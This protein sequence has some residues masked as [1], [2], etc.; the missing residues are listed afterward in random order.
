[1]II[2]KVNNI[3]FS[4]RNVDFTAHVV[5]SPDVKGDIMIP[6]SITYTNREYII[7]T[8]E[9]KSFMNNKLLKSITFPEDSELL[10]IRNEAFLYSSIEYLTI[11]SKVQ[12]MEEGWCSNVKHLKNVILSPNNPNFIY[13]DEDRKMIAS[14][15]DQNSNNYDNLI[16]ACRDIEY[17]IIPSFIKRI[18]DHCFQFC[19][20]IKNFEFIDIESSQLLSIGKWSFHQSSISEIEIPKQ[21]Q[22][23]QQEAF[24]CCSNL[25]KIEI[26]E[27]SKLNEID[28][29]SFS[30][31]SIENFFIPSNV[32]IIQEGCFN[33]SLNLKKVT[34]SLENKHFKY[35]DFERKI[36]V[37]KSNKNINDYDVIIFACREISNAFIPSF[38]TRINQFAFSFCVN[39]NEVKFEKNSKLNS[40]G[41]CAFAFS[42]LKKISFPSQIKIIDDKAFLQCIKLKSITFKKPKKLKNDNSN[43]LNGQNYDGLKGQNL[44]VQKI[45]NFNVQNLNSLRSSNKFRDIRNL[46]GN[47]SAEENMKLQINGDVFFLCKNLKSFEFLGDSVQIGKLCFYDCSDFIV[48]S[49]PNAQ[50]VVASFDAFRKVEKDFTI[51]IK[52]GSTFEVIND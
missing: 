42:M 45:G 6:R 31:C 37:G 52:F 25:R 21:T 16:F 18:S 26:S 39:L 11:P 5:N 35:L 34:L 13:I 44:N 19:S 12:K 22:I 49:F 38:I 24:Y 36:I 3:S 27:D 32:R 23:I 51:F 20:K 28:R 48:A 40:I 1:M 50:K 46:R 14:K 33:Y 7:T 17:A 15:I 2:K 47:V 8:I 43:Q 10:L 9:S 41:Y 29:G 4:L 30:K